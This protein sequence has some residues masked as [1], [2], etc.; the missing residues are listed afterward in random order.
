MFRVDKQS[1]FKR[2][3]Y[4]FM[5]QLRSDESKSRE[6]L[7]L[8]LTQKLLENQRR[9]RKTSVDEMA[10]KLSEQNLSSNTRKKE[11]ETAALS[12]AEI[13]REEEEKRR[14]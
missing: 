8:K 2:Q 7:T 10:K 13:E 11:D 3:D 14:R 1:N 4:A 12:D 6:N 5:K 9:G